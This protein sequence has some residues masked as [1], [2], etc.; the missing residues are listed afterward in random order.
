[1]YWH[2][3]IIIF[4]ERYPQP[5]NLMMETC[6][7]TDIAK[8]EDLGS[9]GL[10]YIKVGVSADGNTWENLKKFTESLSKI[11]NRVL[12]NKL[13]LVLMITDKHSLNL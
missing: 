8:I 9:V 13:I 11:K 4:A 2:L 12:E 6:P 5:S 3:E 10:D 7:E 1:M